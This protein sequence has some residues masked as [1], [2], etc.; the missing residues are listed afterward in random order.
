MKNIDDLN[1]D[2]KVN[3]I[4]K[5]DFWFI[6]LTPVFGIFYFQQFEYAFLQS[7]DQ[8]VSTVKLEKDLYLTPRVGIPNW[9]DHYI[10][11]LIAALIS[12]FLTTFICGGITRSCTHKIDS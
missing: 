4:K 1:N 5:A 9:G 2:Q 12:L 8:V 6:F 11:R 7:I 10:Y 3:P